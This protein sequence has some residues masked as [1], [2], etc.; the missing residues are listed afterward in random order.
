MTQGVAQGMLMSASVTAQQ[1]LMRSNHM[2][3][4]E[5][6]GCRWET[7]VNDHIAL[8]TAVRVAMLMAITGF[9]THQFVTE[10][11]DGA[12]ANQSAVELFEREAARCALVEDI[13]PPQTTTKVGLDQDQTFQLDVRA[14][15][16][17]TDVGGPGHAGLS[18]R[19]WSWPKG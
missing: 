9:V 19:S 5:E 16:G 8:A 6:E 2:T 4:L 13:R 1:G 10:T 15:D 3:G 18:S 14:Q 12:R 7:A 11:R 17:G